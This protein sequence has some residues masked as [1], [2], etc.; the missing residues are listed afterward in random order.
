MRTIHKELDLY[1]IYR[2]KY[3]REDGTMKRVLLFDD[4]AEAGKA[5]LTAHGCELK[6][7]T[8]K[9]EAGRIRDIQEFGPEAIISKTDSPVTA[10]MIDA[11][12]DLKIL[13]RHG[14]GV[15]N[16]DTAYAH[17]KGIYVTNVPGGNAVSVAEM[18]MFMI[19][20]CAKQYGAVRDHFSKGEFDVRYRIIG[21]ELAGKTLGLVGTGHIGKRLARMASG[22]FG[23]KVIGFSRHAQPGTVTAEGI[24]MQESRDDVVKKADYVVLCLPSTPETRH[25]F[26][27]REFG[28]MKKTASFINVSRGNI[29]VESDLIHALQNGEIASAGVDVFDP[30]PPAKT[31]PLLH[32]E[33]VIAT[34]H[35]A[36][37]TKDALERLALGAAKNVLQA[38]SGEE[39]DHQI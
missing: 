39:P 3:T 23:M 21:V 18:A 9:S 7:S 25:S 29:V 6:I 13:A 38:L 34:P 24:E 33:N 11:G 22:G 32:M 10:A 35:Y 36:A 2:Y 20:A 5:L 17:E 12:K 4:M 31:N 15:D 1:Y 16:I 8:D 28:L 37:V 27:A 14:V 30:E 26:G 19:L